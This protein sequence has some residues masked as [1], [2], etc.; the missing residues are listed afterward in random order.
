[1]SDRA[2]TALSFASGWFA[3]RAGT[4]RGRPGDRLSVTAD[5][6]GNADV[7]A[8]IRRG[9]CSFVPASRELPFLLTNPEDGT[10]T[11]FGGAVLAIPFREIERG[12]WVLK[13]TLTPRRLGGRRM[14]RAV[15]PQLLRLPPGGAG[16]SS[17]CRQRCATDRAY[18]SA[19]SSFRTPRIGVRAPQ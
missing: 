8:H 16:T 18:A 7:H 10:E 14:R 1:M 6:P 15:D 5:A 9:S 17:S 12:G 2:R 19:I 3:Y 13:P 4:G 11:A